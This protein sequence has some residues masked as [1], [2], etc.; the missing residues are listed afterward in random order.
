M[1]FFTGLFL[2]VR[3]WIWLYFL[4]SMF[5]GLFVAIYFFKERIKRKY[6][7]I[8]YPEKL[9]KTVIHYKSG[10]FKEYWRIIPDDNFLKCEGKIYNFLNT[11]LIKG[12]DLFIDKE[13]DKS[14]IQ[15]NGNTYELKDFSII[16]KR[17]RKYPEIHYFFNSPNPIFFDVGKKKVD[18]SSKQLESFK[19]NDLF[20]KLLTMET[21]KRILTILLIMMIINTIGTILIFAKLMGWLK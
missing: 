12:N 6:Y 21:E 7:E 2:G 1:G 19:E 9:I 18:L 5:M 4:F 14:K 16:K 3:I 15:I 13:K 20:A 8:R 11:N 10:M 17:W